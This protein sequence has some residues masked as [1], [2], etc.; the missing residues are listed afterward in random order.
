MLDVVNGFSI[1]KINPLQHCHYLLVLR[2][3]ALHLFELLQL[4]YLH[5][6]VLALPPLHQLA[7]QTMLSKHLN[8]ADLQRFASM[9]RRKTKSLSLRAILSLHFYANELF[10]AR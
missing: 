1:A 8:C 7:H 2:Q 5:A 9:L 10:T 6:R 4:T 3:L